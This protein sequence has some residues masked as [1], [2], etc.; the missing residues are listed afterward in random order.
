MDPETRSQDPM[1]RS[2]RRKGSVPA[3]QIVNPIIR[4]EFEQ[5]LR[6]WIN[7]KNH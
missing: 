1:P 2:G 4:G 5:K 6:R 7:L 3:E